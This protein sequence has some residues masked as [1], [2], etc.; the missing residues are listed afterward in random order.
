ML[1][2][3]GPGPTPE[4]LDGH[5]RR[6]QSWDIY[7]GIGQAMESKYLWDSFWPHTYHHMK[8]LMDEPA[9]RP[10]MTVADFEAANDIH[11]EYKLPIAIVCPHMLAF[12]LPCPYIQATPASNCR[13]PG[14]VGRFVDSSNPVSLEN[15]ITF[16]YLRSG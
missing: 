10:N 8:K 13:G 15:G 4:Q 6:M 16:L 5:Y 11:Y 7:K 3:L 12:Q 1:H 14:S 2:L 9:T